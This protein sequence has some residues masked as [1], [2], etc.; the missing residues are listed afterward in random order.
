MKKRQSIYNLFRA[1]MW[2]HCYPLWM[3]LK[4]AVA[5]GVPHVGI[6][7]WTDQPTITKYVESIWSMGV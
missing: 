5:S 1:S 4:E 2:L 7:Y 3:E 6:P